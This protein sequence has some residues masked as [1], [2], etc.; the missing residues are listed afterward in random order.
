M[1]WALI[2]CRVAYKFV[3]FRSKHV[4][5]V[6]CKARRGKSQKGRAPQRLD[7]EQSNRYCPTILLGKIQTGGK[8]CQIQQQSVGYHVPEPDSIV[9]IPPEPGCRRAA[10]P[11]HRSSASASCACAGTRVW[12]PVGRDHP[13]V[14]C[15]ANK[16]TRINHVADALY[17]L[18]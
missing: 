2:G 16:R 9:R 1:F 5:V 6:G 13:E 15:S 14:R 3:E 12:G 7:R 10:R 11:K 4:E 18:P 8:C 17:A